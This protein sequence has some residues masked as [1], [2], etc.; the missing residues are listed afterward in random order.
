MVGAKSR[1]GL[2]VISAGACE[3]VVK[4]GDDETTLASRGV[5]QAT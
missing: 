2:D 3:A 4:V 5:Q 1:L